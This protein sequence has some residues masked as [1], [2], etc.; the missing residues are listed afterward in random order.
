MHVARK[1][2]RNMYYRK[3]G[4]QFS[5][6][7]EVQIDQRMEHPSTDERAEPQINNRVSP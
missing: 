2:V 1:V 4:T 3:L 6:R 5:G 7:C